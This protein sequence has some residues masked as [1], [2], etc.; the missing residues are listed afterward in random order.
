MT[1][2]QSVTETFRQMKRQPFGLEALRSLPG[3][4]PAPLLR[5]FTVDCLGDDDKIS[6]MSRWRA[7]NSQAFPRLFSVTDARTRFWADRLL[8]KRSDR[9]LF[10][11]DVAGRLVGHVG[12]SSFDFSHGTCE[13][14][15]IVR[16]EADA[17][18]GVM[19]IAVHTLMEWTYATLG[20]RE[21]KLRVMHENTRALALYHGLGFVP[22]ALLP[23]KKVDHADSGETEWQPSTPGERIDRFYLVMTHA[24]L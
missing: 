21:I 1:V 19:R 8:L 4:S 16:G 6:L 20:V 11:V 13:I 7:E 18:P 23:L 12:L 2:E 17:P 24:H 5:P 15:N 9:M 3:I 10:F 22:E 14:D